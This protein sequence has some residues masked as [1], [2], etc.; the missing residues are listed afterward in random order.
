M[1]FVKYV[2]NHLIGKTKRKQIQINMQATASTEVACWLFNIPIINNF[3][4][5]QTY[6]VQCG[7]YFL[8]SY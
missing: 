4:S 6:S 2:N 3:R 8:D 7:C 1:F 5:Q